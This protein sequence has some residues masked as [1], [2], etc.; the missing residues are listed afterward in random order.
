MVPG[1]LQP[2]LLLDQCLTEES[3]NSGLQSPRPLTKLIKTWTKKLGG[4]MH[5][6]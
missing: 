1:Q 2:Q 3:R 5:W 6:P 4:E